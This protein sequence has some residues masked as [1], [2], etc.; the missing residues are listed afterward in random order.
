M[1]STH[2]IISCTEP[3]PTLPQMYGSVPSCSHKIQ[4]LVRAEV[5]VLDHAAPMR[6]DHLRTLFARPDAVLPV[7]LVGETA[8]RPAEHRDLQL[9]QGR[10]HV[11]AN[12]PRVGNRRILAHPDATVDAVAQMLGKVAVDVAIHRGT[13]L[14]GAEDQGGRRLLREPGRGPHGQQ[15]QSKEQYESN[16]PSSDK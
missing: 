12:A 13:R 15:G 3:L 5:V 16:E 7:I 8:T 14:I 4:E 6:V 1:Y 11:V 2:S 10:D 9:A